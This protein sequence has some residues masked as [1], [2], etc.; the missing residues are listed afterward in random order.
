MAFRV[1]LT[2]AS[3][4]TTQC[5]CRDGYV[6][7]Q[8]NIKG[9]SRPL[10]V[11]VKLKIKVLRVKIKKIIIIFEVNFFFFFWENL[12]AWG[13]DNIDVIYDL[14]RLKHVLQWCSLHNRSLFATVRTLF[15][16]TV[17]TN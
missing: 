11:R 7:H 9:R 13:P 15:N 5:P 17:T 12:G 4:S 14:C 2:H 16:L 6:G 8:Y 10:Q 3:N 1:Q